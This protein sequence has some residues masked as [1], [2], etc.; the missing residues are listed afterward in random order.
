VCR[1]APRHTGSP[2]SP[3]PPPSIIRRPGPCSNVMG[4][5]LLATSASRG[6]PVCDTSADSPLRVDHL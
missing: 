1:L 2:Y 3:R 5:L 6:A 4:S